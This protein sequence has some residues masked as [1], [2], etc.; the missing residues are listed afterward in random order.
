MKNGVKTMNQSK[1][2]AISGI[3]GVIAYFIAV[4]LFLITKFDW[5]LTLWEIMTVAGALLEAAILIT[6][7]D[8]TEMSS[9]WQTFMKISLTGM[10]ILT[11]L[12]HFTSIGVVRPLATQGAE[13]PEYF[14]IGTFPSLEMTADYTAWGFF[15]GLAFMCLYFGITKSKVM[16]ILSGVCTGL[17]FIG[18]IGSF[19]N[20]SLWYFAPW[21][22]GG[23][24]LIMCIYML[25]KADKK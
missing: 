23:G 12:A 19:F 11:S 25:R 10:L 16:K 6:V 18:F 17:C 4:A 5:A 13:I 21:G 9:L 3:V 1:K 2:A 24:F 14:Q 8:K 15:L 7:T 22:Y 20:E